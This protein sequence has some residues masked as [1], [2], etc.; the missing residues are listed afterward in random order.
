M[1][2]EREKVPFVGRSSVVF[3]SKTRSPQAQ[4]DT[5][6]TKRK[7]DELE[8]RERV[9]FFFGVI[10]SFPPFLFGVRRG[11]GAVGTMKKFRTPESRKRVFGGFLQLKQILL[12]PPS[13]LRNCAEKQ[14]EKN[15][16]AFFLSPPPAVSP[17][18]PLL[19]Q[20]KVSSGL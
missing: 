5:K 2:R 19:L 12:L 11:R 13:I 1:A 4:S 10:V 3:P 16:W 6:T 8:D 9:L 14:E 18:P 7:R 20:R 15:I 17:P